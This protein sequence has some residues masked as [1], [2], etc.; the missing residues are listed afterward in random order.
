MTHDNRVYKSQT[1]NRCQIECNYIMSKYIKIPFSGEQSLL[2]AWKTNACCTCIPDPQHLG[3]GWS[4]FGFWQVLLHWD[5]SSAAQQLSACWVS[6]IREHDKHPCSEQGDEK[7]RARVV[8]ERHRKNK[9]ASSQRM[10]MVQ[11][12]PLESP[13]KSQ[14]I[15]KYESKKSQIS[16]QQKLVMASEACA[17]QWQFTSSW[18]WHLESQLLS[19]FTS[20]SVWQSE[21]LHWPLADWRDRSPADCDIGQSPTSS[22]QWASNLP[23]SW[24]HLLWS[25]PSVHGRACHVSGSN[26]LFG[27]LFRKIGKASCFQLDLG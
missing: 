18:S 27:E 2:V 25:R 26:K 11:I 16:N 7:T 22:L 13:G 17:S 21:I 12:D 9:E 19:F 23:C 1:L 6:G 3:P 8:S 20:G 5:Q 4:T 24:N 14:H 15:V 10:Q